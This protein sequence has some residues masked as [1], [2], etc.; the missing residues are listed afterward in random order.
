MWVSHAESDRVLDFEVKCKK[1]SV[2]KQN[3]VKGP[4]NKHVCTSNYTGRYI[5]YIIR[6]VKYN[7]CS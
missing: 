4:V 3:K 7:I 5:I 2:C 6:E 1:C